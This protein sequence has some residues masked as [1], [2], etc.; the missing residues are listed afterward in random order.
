MP[1]TKRCDAINRTRARASRAP[2][3][4]AFE[5]V[6]EYLVPMWLDA[7][8]VTI[9][10]EG[11]GGLTETTRFFPLWSAHTAARRPLMSRRLCA[12]RRLNALTALGVAF[13]RR[14]GR[15]T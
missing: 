11:D 12:V 2:R 9:E 10:E 14:A 3:E 6:S 8:P 1:S 4:P 7:H 5:G 15:C 13:D